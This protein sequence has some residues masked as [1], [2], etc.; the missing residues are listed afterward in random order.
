MLPY[1]WCLF[2][3]VK[4]EGFVDVETKNAQVYREGVALETQD[5]TATAPRERDT[6]ADIGYQ[7]GQIRGTSW[8][9]GFLVVLGI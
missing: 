5:G 8:N 1:L 4:R 6:F 3:G 2:V 7:N 9:G